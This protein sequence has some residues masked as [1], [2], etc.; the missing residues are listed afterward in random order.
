MNTLSTQV[1][2]CNR[3][4]SF[5]ICTLLMLLTGVQSSFATIHSNS[6][7]T[8]WTDA[9]TP[10]NVLNEYPRPILERTDWLNLNGYWDFAIEDKGGKQPEQYDRQILV[11]FVPESMLSGI[12]CQVSAKDELWYR[13]TFC[14]PEEWNGKNILL[15]FGAVDWKAEV[16]VNGKRMGKHE[17]GYTSFSFD[18]TSAIDL[19]NDEQEI[20]VKVWDPTEDSY[21]PRGKQSLNPSGIS[22]TAASGIW[23]TV[24]LEP[25]NETH[26]SRFVTTPDIDNATIKITSNIEGKG[27]DCI[28][29]VKVK[30]NG[31][32]VAQQ[33]FSNICPLIPVTIDMPEDFLLWTPDAPHLY[34]IEVVLRNGEEELDRFTSYTAMRKFSVG[35]NKKINLNNEPIFQMGILDQG[36][37]PDG[38]YTAPTDSALMFDI[39]KAKKMGFNMIR[40]HLKVESARWYTYCD[41]IGMIVWQDMPNGDKD[42]GVCLQYP[43]KGE[44]ESYRTKTSENNFMKEWQEIMDQLIGYP[45][46][47]TWV[48]FNEAMG[49]FNT[50]KI[51]EWT[52]THD[53][54]RIVDA[55]SGGNY[56]KQCGDI[57]DMHHYPN[58][59]LK[60]IDFKMVHAIGEY[61][62][63]AHTVEGHTWST[64][65]NWGYATCKTKE[66]LVERYEEYAKT[67]NQLKTYDLSAAVYTQLT[68][69]ELEINGFMTYDRAVTKVDEEEILRINCDI[70]YSPWNIDVCEVDGYTESMF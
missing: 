29:E 33:E 21:Q 41:R 58:P 32:V 30:Y 40:K 66:E 4:L 11:P 5:A 52:K 34:D 59:M 23:Q 12:E 28:M 63:L 38:I 15:N 10:D 50:R 31:E 47:G 60:F 55:A 68:D 7:T 62:G 70:I 24:W 18:I 36:Y 6:M 1:A 61:G 49:Q 46:I 19:E 8:A 16:W 9:V 69:V 3:H 27:E 26:I 54:T 14:V 39:M 48:I 64:E 35:R 56:Y 43:Y 42:V 44:V 20:V 57:L 53:R 2:T 45:C 13:R 67:L 17:G 25:V 22:Y 37:W 51:T 65:N